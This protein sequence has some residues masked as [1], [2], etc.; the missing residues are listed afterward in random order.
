M[1]GSDAVKAAVGG[2]TGKMMTF[3][4]SEGEYSV[5]TKPEDIDKIANMVREVP[6]EF[7][8]KEGN[9]VTDKCLEYI[10]P[11]IKGETDP[12]YKNGLPVHFV[13]K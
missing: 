7:I 10:L 4:R 5:T 13:I 6:R 3:V 2:E 11:L 9:N 8:N 1:V 12:V